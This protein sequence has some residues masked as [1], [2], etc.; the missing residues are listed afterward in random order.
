[1]KISMLSFML[2]EDSLSVHDS[3]VNSLD[4]IITLPPPYDFIGINKK[5]VAREGEL[6]AIKRFV[7]LDYKRFKFWMGWCKQNNRPA[8]EQ[9]TQF[10]ND[11][12][13]LS[14]LRRQGKAGVMA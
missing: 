14:Q 2:F 9:L 11:L 10:F 12:A 3:T 6:V 8:Y 4:D 1:M 13:L 5:K 7:V